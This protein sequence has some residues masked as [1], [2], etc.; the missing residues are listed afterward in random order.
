MAPQRGLMPG[1]TAQR[2]DLFGH[3]NPPGLILHLASALTW[4]LCLSPLLALSMWLEHFFGLTLPPQAGFS[5]CC[6]SIVI[7]ELELQISIT[8]CHHILHSHFT[9]YMTEYQRGWMTTLKKS[10]VRP[11]HWTLR[12]YM[13]HSNVQK[14]EGGVP[15]F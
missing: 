13:Y 12:V 11:S 7:V 15:S 5:Q 1:I 2:D 8:L 6:L 10:R 4:T 14:G 3:A 9:G